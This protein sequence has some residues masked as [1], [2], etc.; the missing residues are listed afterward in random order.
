MAQ[1]NQIFGAKY[2]PEYCANYLI[3]HGMRKI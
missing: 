2:I 1:K 3:N